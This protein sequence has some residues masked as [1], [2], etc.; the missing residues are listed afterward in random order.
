MHSL[1]THRYN[2]VKF[3]KEDRN[4]AASYCYSSA[5]GKSPGW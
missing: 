3:S 4:A 2:G 5:F 1:Y